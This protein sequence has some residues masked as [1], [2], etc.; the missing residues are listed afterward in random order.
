MSRQLPF[1]EAVRRGDTSAVVRLL[2]QDPELTRSV[3]E[4]GKTGLHWAA[5][6]D[7]PEIA[8]ALLDR[9]AELEARTSWGATPLE[10][11]SVMGSG[12]AAR[13]LLSRGAGG[14]TVIVAAGL[15]MLDAVKGMLA[16]GVD[17]WEH[18]RRGAP[19]SPDEHWPQDSAHLRGDVVSDAMYAAARNGHTAVVAF[20]LDSGAEVDSRGVFGGTALHWAAI[21]GHGSTAELLR[22]RGASLVVRD[23]RFDATPAEWALEGG[24]R[25]V[26]EALR[27]DR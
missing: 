23:A 2:D 13:E 6:V 24:H 15:G 7:R 26:A 22:S 27:P 5:E 20:L 9:G 17:L 25:E 10:W 18:R 3:D 1:L 14:L 21:H 19:D 12:E 16:S 8:A 4:D 11:A